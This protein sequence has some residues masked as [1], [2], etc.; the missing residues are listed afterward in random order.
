MSITAVHRQEQKKTR[1]YYSD[2][3]F[4][5]TILPPDAVSRLLL[6]SFG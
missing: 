2:V 6:A 5:S 4:T 3:S 1:I